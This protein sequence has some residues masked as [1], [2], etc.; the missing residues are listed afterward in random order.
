[1]ITKRGWENN[2]QHGNTIKTNDLSDIFCCYY[3]KFGHT[4]RYYKKLQ[5]KNQK[6]PIVTVA[7]LSSF[8]ANIIT[9]S[10]KEYA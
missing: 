2:N 6:T 5:N 9:I 10:A 8:S 1:M 7:T 3:V 4:K